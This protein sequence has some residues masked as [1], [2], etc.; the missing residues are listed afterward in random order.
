MLGSFFVLPFIFIIFVVS[1]RVHYTHDLQLI[2]TNS[3]DNPDIVTY[4]E[5]RLFSDLA[6]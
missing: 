5:N 4:I 3:R 6:N 1:K 2:E